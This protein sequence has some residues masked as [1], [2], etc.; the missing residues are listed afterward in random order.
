MLP[1]TIT[2]SNIKQKQKE[3]LSYFYD[4]YELFE[5]LFDM[6]KDDSVFYKKSE[7]T[8]HPMI[9][10][11]G[12]TATFFI[13]KL[14]LAKIIDK[15]VN[16]DFESIFAIG[17]DEMSW[18]D[19]DESRYT[20]PKVDDVREYRDSV[21][22]IVSELILSI[23]L[24][25]PIKQNDPMWIILM[26]IEHE[27][28]HIETSSVLH[29]QMPIEYIKKIDSFPICKIDNPLIKNRLV[30]IHEAS[31]RLGK[32]EDHHL[33]GW[34]NEY[35]SLSVN[36]K[37]FQVSK[38][39]VSNGEFLEFVKAG[40]YGKKEYWD[41]EGLEFLQNTKATIPPFWII[42]KDGQYSYRTIMEIIPLPLSWPVE[43]S[44]LE[45]YAFC[46][47]KS[48][49]GDLNY[50][51]PS[52]EEYYAIYEQ[53]GLE[54]IPC[55]D[56]TKAN[57][58][59]RHYGSAAPVDSFVFNEIYDVVGNVWQH[60]R[61]PIYPYTGFKVHPIYDDFSVPTFD[62]KHNLMKGGSFISTGN[63][64]MKHSRY[65][66]RRHFYQH[67]G[68]R[69]VVGD[70]KFDI[71]SSIVE[72][73]FINSELNKHLNTDK[74]TKQFEYIKTLIG[75]YNHNKILEIG[76]SIGVGSIALSSIYKEVVGVD[77]TARIIKEAEQ[78]LNGFKDI[79]NISYWQV[80]PC[81]IKVNYK[82]FDLIVL[83]DILSRVYS[84]ILLLQELENRLNTN[85]ILVTIIKNEDDISIL[86][87]SFKAINEETIEDN[88][89]IL[90]ERI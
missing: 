5:K 18:D 14:I 47:W 44:A 66:F 11:F 49:I 55:F 72:D 78:Y 86:N 64:M 29:R 41:E 48:E 59:L 77:T 8:R 52:E 24:T 20:W 50:T 67:A 42:D 35:S 40:G 1:I 32:D 19:L 30:T 80:D 58:N 85:G 6:L 53:S 17:V 12:H 21:K 63:E 34:D 88:K 2:G 28:I 4:S 68:F 84:P 54:D 27:R 89:I 76:C 69:Y 16:P 62:E 61:T 60:T 43:I 13:N 46:K 81:N 56:D 22:K 73:D 37:E 51:L 57:I 36:I 75:G 90:W 9:F 74:I 70:E 7:S 79:T 82:D 25:L 45:A 65:A 26:G 38:Y 33:Y 10:Y 15:R 83:N 3:I 23:P 71:K 39:L 31:L 87:E